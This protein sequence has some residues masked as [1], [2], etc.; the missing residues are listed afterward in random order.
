MLAPLLVAATANSGAFRAVVAA[1]SSATGELRLDTT[2]IRL[3]QEFG[4]APSRVRFTL[5]ADLVES[6]TRRVVAWREFDMS[7]AVASDDPYGGA[8]AAGKAVSGTLEELARFCSAATA[9]WRS[10]ARAAPGSIRP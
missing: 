2:I 5:R 6:A 3:Q 7:V 8:I 4:S 10:T 1:P 9:A